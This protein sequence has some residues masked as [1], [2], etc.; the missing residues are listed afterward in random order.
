MDY[1]RIASS[2]Q[3][4][5]KASQ[6]SAFAR[7]WTHSLYRYPASMSPSIARSL[8]K[9]ITEPGDIILDPFCGGG[10]TA[11]E[12]LVH[13]RRALCSDLNNLAC[14]ITRSKAS[15]VSKAGIKRLREWVFEIAT[16]I[17]HS[18]DI[19]PM[20]LITADGTRYAPFTHGL[21]VKL[22][23]AT[24]EI[25]GTKIRQLA[26]LIVLRTGQVCFDCREKPPSPHHLKR[27]FLKTAYETIEKVEIYSARCAEFKIAN[28]HGQ[29]LQVLCTD[30]EKITQI[31]GDKIESISLVLTSP[32]YPGVHVLY[33]R[34]QFRG[35]KEISLPYTIAGLENGASE[36]HYTL[37]SRQE[38]ENDTYFSRLLQ[39]F[40]NLNNALTPGTPIAQVVAFSRPETQLNKYL[41]GMRMAGFS[42]IKSL[43]KGKPIV[44]R[45]IPN[46]RWYIRTGSIQSS[47]CEYLLLHCSSGA[48]M[49][50]GFR[51]KVVGQTLKK[52]HL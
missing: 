19:I 52:E 11:I 10:T 29:P 3:D 43:N 48:K 25:H 39:I 33:H 6:D 13:G 36:S 8:I 15:T 44:Q 16:P 51:G 5:Y 26:Q 30:A 1:T 27:V 35:R 20:P 31:L 49:R 37:G 4:I 40:T 9:V 47:M 14:F 24:H 18:R 21:L 28:G 12:A 42:E 41:E 17:L 7:D 34:W 22:R 46:R 38:R 23:E 50:N 45:T 32:P 2:L